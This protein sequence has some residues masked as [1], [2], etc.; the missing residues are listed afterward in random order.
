MITYIAF[1][2]I[3]NALNKLCISSYNQKLVLRV[4]TFN[5]R[6]NEILKISSFHR[7]NNHKELNNTVTHAESLLIIL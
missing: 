3:S 5:G 2:S 7:Y 6:F 4:H 1:N